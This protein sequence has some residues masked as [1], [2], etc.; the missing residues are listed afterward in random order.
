M[1][2]Y[3]GKE[4]KYRFKKCDFIFIGKIDCKCPNCVHTEFSI[5]TSSEIVSELTR[6]KNNIKSKIK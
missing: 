2:L 5:L 3:N 6:E 4:H 1:Y